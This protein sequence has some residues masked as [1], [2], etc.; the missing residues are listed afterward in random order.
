MCLELV[1]RFVLGLGTP[2][3]YVADPQIEYMLKPNQDVRRFGN[4]I[5][6]NQWGMRSEPFEAAKASRDEFRV[7]VFGDSV[8]NGGSQIDHAELA[9]T[10]LAQSLQA[11]LQR[12]VVVGNASA[13][14]WGPGNWLAYLQRYG[15]LNTDA[16]V[17]L[18]NSG[19]YAD[20][21]SFAPLNPATHPTGQPWLALDESINRYLPR[22]LPKRQTSTDSDP[23]RAEPPEAEVERGLGD[24]RSFLAMWQRSGTPVVIV[25]HPDRQETY[26][27]RYFAGHDRMQG[28]GAELGIPFIELRAAYLTAGAQGLYRDDI[29][30][31]AKG[32]AV[33]A[34]A[35]EKHVMT[36][37]RAV[38]R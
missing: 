11:K 1:C 35:L 22:Y 25:H 33:L 17:L 10:L 23:P 13:G 18:V 26:T 16:V 38:P 29:H 24:L 6:V 3:L 32:Q 2:P 36:L 19:D 31:S 12:P 28:L 9:S 34:T 8:I 5:L 4:R 15:S 14:S 20:N 30:Q 37:V 21:P 27:G 7:L